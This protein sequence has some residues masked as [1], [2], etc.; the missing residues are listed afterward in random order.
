[1]KRKLTL[2]LILTSISLLVSVTIVHAPWSTLGT[3]YAVTSNYHGSDIPLG[4]SVTVTAGTLDPNVVTITFRW[5]RPPDGNGPVAWEDIIPVWQNGTKGQWNNGNWALIWYAENTHT[6]DEVGEWGIQAF[7]QD[8]EGNNRA[9]VPQVVKIKAT[10]LNAVPEVPFG[11]IAIFV[12][13][14]GALSVF[15]LKKKPRLTFSH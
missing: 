2:A 6:L 12:A 15:A 5:H 7:F 13:M 10:S 11:T 3:G 14:L 8:S 4:T 9:E 1:M